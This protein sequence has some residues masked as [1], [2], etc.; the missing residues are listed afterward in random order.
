VPVHDIT[1]NGAVGAQIYSPTQQGLARARSMSGRFEQHYRFVSA[2][3]RRASHQCPAQILV[4]TLTTLS[5]HLGN[6]GYHSGPVFIP[7]P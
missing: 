7:L 3:K 5:Q 1:V 2:E 4:N 6:I